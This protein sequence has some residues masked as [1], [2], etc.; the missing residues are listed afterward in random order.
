[1]TLA[2]RPSSTTKISTPR[3]SE[4]ARHVIAP[5][6][7]VKSGW[8]QVAAL[9]A[10]FGV[11]FDQWQVDIA[12]LILAKRSDGQY[13]ADTAVLS[14]PRQVGKTYL[15]GCLV[16]AL[17]ILKP[18]LLV[19]WTAHH[20]ATSDETFADMRA[21][22]SLPRLA[23][24][25]I[26]VRA[27]NG[28]QSIIFQN[29]SRIRFGARERGFGRGFKKVGVL[30]L[31]E[32][33]ILTANA[34]DNLIPTTARADNPLVL[35]AGTPPKPTDPGEAFTA[36]RTE[37]LEA[38]SGTGETLYVEFSAD[39]DA[40]PRDRQQWAKANPSYPRHTKSRA[41]LRML[42]SLGPASFR[43]EALGIWDAVSVASPLL[44]L[45]DWSTLTDSPPMDGAHAYGVR[46]SA[47]GSRMALSVAIT[48]PDGRV[49]IET[50]DNDSTAVGLTGLTRW[51]AD[52]ADAAD[53]IV[54]DGLSNAGL[55]VE[56]LIAAGVSSRQIVRV[57]P[58]E[59]TTAADRLVQLAKKRR[60]AHAGQAGWATV[61][62]SAVR[63]DIGK[64]GAWGFGVAG[65]SEADV[66]PIEAASLAISGLHD[67]PT[68]DEDFE[69][70]P[71]RG[72]R[73]STRRRGSV[74]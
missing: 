47:S 69:A 57:G 21:I 20:T 8:P 64:F 18:G 44:A 46:F 7:I 16:I 22:V 55:L 28:Q 12:R 56:S 27:A 32:A 1:M 26:Q 42:K 54:I 66:T 53:H 40:D 49:F 19:I 23:K 50:L 15:L 5:R 52:R 72:Q 11:V 39:E 68:I 29:K 41:I 73:R 58:G 67:K 13:A 35:M 37:A 10:I 3:L 63:R 33:Q 71:S 51:L 61:I 14:I 74:M 59:V 48:M 36:M 9:L 31:D 24:L 34:M 43:R 62:P 30:V 6:G 45:D 2:P 25:G 38:G 65:D 4:V 17:C 60:L 70:P